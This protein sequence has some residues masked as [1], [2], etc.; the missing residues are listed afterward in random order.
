MVIKYSDDSSS[1][2]GLE[3]ELIIKLD[4]KMILH[5]NIDITLGFVNGAIGT[6]SSV[7][8]SIDRASLVESMTIHYGED[9]F[10]QLTRVK[11]KFQVL[12][13]TNVIMQQFPI[14]NA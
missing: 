1:T 4:Y 3:K 8:F 11:R 6:V 10:H 5:R 2:A 9:K 13:K 14:T 12:E 7:K